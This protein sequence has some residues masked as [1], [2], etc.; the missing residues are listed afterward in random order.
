MGGVLWQEVI[1]SQLSSLMNVS[2]NSWSNTIFLFRG[3][4]TRAGCACIRDAIQRGLTVC[5]SDELQKIPKLRNLRLDSQTAHFQNWRAIRI[6]DLFLRMSIL[7]LRTI[8]L[9]SCSPG[10]DLTVTISM[11]TEDNVLRNASFC[12]VSETAFRS[13]LLFFQNFCRVKIPSI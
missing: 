2:G 1:S 12:D 13:F 9:W 11:P 4:Q 6:H 7:D 5:E 10:R 8:H 3:I